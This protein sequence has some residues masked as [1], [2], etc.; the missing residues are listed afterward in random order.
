MAI[1]AIG[2]VRLAWWTPRTLGLLL[3]AFVPYAIFHLLFQE[4]ATVRYALPLVIPVA[5]LV[6]SA[7]ESRGRG[8]LHAGAAAL[9]AWSLIV[10]LPATVTYGRSGSPAFRALAEAAGAG[11]VDPALPERVIG[12]HAGA[13]RAVEW[14]GAA[15]PARV[16]TGPHGREWLTLVEHWKS[17]PRSAVSFVADPRRTDLALFDP[18]ARSAPRPFRWGFVEPPFVGGAR[19]G[20]SDVYAMHPPGWMLDRGWALTAEVGGVTAR[21]GLGPHLKPSVAWIRSRGDE[22]QLTIGG[23]HLGPATDPDVRIGLTLNGS[24]WYT[25][26]A[27][28]GFF[29]IV[30]PVPAGALTASAPYVPLEVTSEAA[31][32]SGRVIAVGLEQFDLQSAGVPM[33]SLAEGW[34]EP[35]YDPRTARSWRWV[36]EHGVLWVRPIGRDVTLRLTGESPLRYF[37]AAPSVTVSVAG[38]QVAR[39]APSTD[40]TQDVVLPADALAS[41][42]GRVVIETD[43]WFVPADRDAVPDRRHLALRIYSLGS[44]VERIPN[45]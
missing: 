15:L 18:A 23:R 42:Q 8:V 4:T 2:F 43:K 13:R 44:A 37:S 16:L 26:D 35:E 38:R 27:K 17:S 1:A 7:L 41:V 20:N 5:Y 33:V 12:I 31:D 24:P 10:T 39:F 3:V 6:A 28:P 22:A 29:F 25:F 40:F 21:D 36:S 32:D 19:P 11:A 34:H 30:M 45:H 9:A 14:M